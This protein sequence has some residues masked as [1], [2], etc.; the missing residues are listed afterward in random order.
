MLSAIGHT[1]DVHLSDYVA[2][3]TRTIFRDTE[4][5]WDDLFTKMGRRYEKP[6]LVLFG[7][8][9]TSACGLADAAVGP[10]YCPGDSKVYIDMQFYTDMQR[11]L[12]AQARRRP[13]RPRGRR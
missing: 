6:T 9:V 11:K 3:F 7:G 1:Q 13:V 2:D 12:N 5:V 10:F 4:I 8:E